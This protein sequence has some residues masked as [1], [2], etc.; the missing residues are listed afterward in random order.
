MISKYKLIILIPIYISLNI[1][2]QSFQRDINWNFQQTSNK[3]QNLTIDCGYLFFENAVFDDHE[4]MIPSYFELFPISSSINSIEQLKIAIVNSQYSKLTD[5]ELKKIKSVK[6]IGLLKPF[7]SVQ[8]SRK[9]NFLAAT[10]PAVRVNSNGE[11]EKLHSFTLSIEESNYSKPQ[12]ILKA[13][14]KTSSVLSNGKWVKVKIGA[15]GVYKLTFSELVSYGLSNVENVSVW[16][17]GG[18]KL[19]YM[20]N[21]SSPDDLEQIPIIIEKGA[22]GI[23]NQGDYILFYAEGPLTWKYEEVNIFFMHE[24]HPYSKEI[25]YFLTT[26][27][28][29]PKRIPDIISTSSPSTYQTNHYDELVAFEK[30]DTNLI[31]SGRDWYGE[32]FDIYTTQNFNTKLNN[33]ELG[34]SV[35]IRTRLSA[36]SSSTSDYN[37]LVN[38]VNLG[39][40]QLDG[41][42]VGDEQSD[43]ISVKQQD[44]TTPAPTGNLIV[45]LTYNKPSPAANGWLDYITVNSRQLLKYQG[46]QLIFRDTKSKGVDAV[47][48]FNVQNTPNTLRIWDISNI[49]FPSSIVYSSGSGNAIFTLP[50]DSLRQFIAF[51]DDKAYSVSLVGDVPN[52]NLH[53]SSHSDMIIVVHPSLLDQAL[54]L[55]E[56]HRTNDGLSVQ[57][58]TTDQVYNEFSSGNRDVSAI[59]NLMRMFYKRSTGSVDMPR[60]LLL[61]GDGSYDNISDKKGNTN[62]IPTYQS[63]ES[64]NKTSSFVTDDFFGLLDDNEGGAIGLLD[65]GIGRFPASN[66]EQSN[67]ILNKIKQYHNQSSLGDWNNQLCFIG[68]DEDGNIHM[69]DANTLADYVKVNHSIYN[70]QKIFFDAY[71]QEST[72]TGDRY[73]DVTLAI[74][75]KVNSGALI[76][77]Y[78]GHGN[79]QWLAH[80]KVLMLDDVRS[81]RNFQKLPLFVTAT[82][83]FSR[84][85]DYNLISTGESILLT[86]NG[87]GI[88]LLSTTRLV[89]SSPNFTLNYNFFQTVF[90]EVSKKS[91][92]STNDNHYRLGDI[93]RITKNISGTGNNKRNFMLLGDP[94]LMLKYP[95]YDIAI[96]SINNAPIATLSDT[97]KAL[98]KVKIVGKITNHST[99]ETVNFN[100]ITSL[101]L[102]DKEKTIKTLSNDGGLPMEFKVRD[103]IIYRGNVTVKDGLFD[104]NC[105]IPKD[106]NYRVGTGR[107]SLFATNGSEAGAGY[108]QTILIGGINSNPYSDDKGPVISIYLNDS[109][110]VSGGISDSNPKLIVDL[111]DSS[112]INTTGTGI[113][114]DLIATIYSNDEKNII[115][116]DYYKA[117]NDSYQRGKAEFQLTNLN[118]GSNKIKIKAWD[119]YNNSSES[120]ISFLVTND[121]KLMISHLL[122]YPNPFTDNTAFYF[123]H[124]Q[125]FTDLN[126]LIQIYSPSGKLV[127]TIH[128]QESTASGFR[129]GPIQWDGK[130]DFGSRIGRGVYFYR[131]RVITSNGK[132]AEQQQKMV[133]LK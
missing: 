60:Y 115:L 79:E 56:I 58:V 91:V 69:T 107:I 113:G 78:T 117:D 114:H 59:R 46:S 40:I 6:K 18:S 86:P 84:F 81:W 65:I 41:V 11:F 43:F 26:D 82:C 131:L 53:G 127:K 99:T 85:D 133:L 66:T 3:N 42:N 118:A 13:L 5:L 22:D 1:S 70:V 94:A 61:F 23:F 125:P 30:N 76:V 111:I 57:V 63:N 48:Q 16:G 47:T 129:I 45:T 108:N 123:E 2:A 80:E 33:Q 95:T 130:D 97:L 51:E 92:S 35:K 10:I 102:Y 38:S 31:K 112:G 9:Q 101:T 106:I 120:E 132:S 67:V 20:N 29:S 103:N 74:S 83:E 126:I 21:V 71:H 98:S 89:Y 8:Q 17:N 24:I 109:K 104:I 110:F 105:I 119:S 36:R 12:N 27:Y 88:G 4:T 128:H 96:T 87:G 50:T 73:P 15:T 39:N 44:F 72:P 28:N 34:S 49:H 75:N 124:N 68:D 19:P 93:V 54:E 32:S 64:I 37:I 121:D 77:N 25:N 14:I 122:N 90:S 62:L 116:N 100:G 7:F 52:Q 55:A